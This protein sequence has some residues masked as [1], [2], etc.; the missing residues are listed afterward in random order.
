MA[1]V[2][3]GC[4]SY[5]LLKAVLSTPLCTDNLVMESTRVLSGSLYELGE[6]SAAE[7]CYK[8]KMV[9]HFNSRFTY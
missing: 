1:T 7:M 9:S 6:S 5:Y 3:L 2:G 4:F 8:E